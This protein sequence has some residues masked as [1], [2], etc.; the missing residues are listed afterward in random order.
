MPK[1][2]WER[3]IQ[4]GKIIDALIQRNQHKEAISLLKQ[5]QT[6]LV[7]RAQK[8]KLLSCKFK[9]SERERYLRLAKADVK[10]ALAIRKFLQG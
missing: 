3:K 8:T 1:L 5:A 10:K 2:K 4:N 6:Q 9:G 7:A